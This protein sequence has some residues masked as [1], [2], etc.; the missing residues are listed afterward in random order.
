MQEEKPK[1]IERPAIEMVGLEVMTDGVRVWTSLLYR[2]LLNDAPVLIRH[3][4]N[5]VH[6]IL[7]FTRAILY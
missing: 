2:E 4:A 3:A 1:L 6:D 7:S 5:R